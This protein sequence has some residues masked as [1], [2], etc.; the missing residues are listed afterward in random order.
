MTLD[1]TVTET[2]PKL[3]QECKSKSKWIKNKDYFAVNIF[4][5]YTCVVIYY[6]LIHFMKTRLSNIFLSTKVMTTVDD[7]FWT[8]EKGASGLEGVR[9]VPVKS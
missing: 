7:V 4:L 5:K 9:N 8:S 2:T 6:L 3:N 1:L